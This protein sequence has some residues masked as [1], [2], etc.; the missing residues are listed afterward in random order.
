[1][2]S[3]SSVEVTTI[4]TVESSVQLMLLRHKQTTQ[5]LAY[6][7]LHRELDDAAIVR[8]AVLQQLP[9]FA[10]VRNRWRLSAKGL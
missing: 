6:W 8:V 1:M 3:I 2:Q 7:N 4:D 9:M 5:E 10:V